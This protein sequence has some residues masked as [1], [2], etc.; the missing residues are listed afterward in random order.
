MSA[1]ED[2]QNSIHFAIKSERLE[3]IVLLLTGLYKEK[4]SLKE[5]KN[6]ISCSFL[7]EQA[8]SAKWIWKSLLGLD[9][10]SESDGFTPFHVAA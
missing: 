3:I 10:S 8:Q 7:I 1:N 9:V 4:V 5:I 2:F 6:E